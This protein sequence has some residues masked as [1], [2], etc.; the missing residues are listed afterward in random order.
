MPRKAFPRKD[1]AHRVVA[2]EVLAKHAAATDRPIGLPVPID[3]II[4]QTYGLEIVWDRLAESPDTMILGALIPQSRRIVLNEVH[5]DMFDRWVGPER[6]TLAHELAHW[7]YDADN[8]DQLALD[9]KVSKT[10]Q[11]CYHPESPRLSD[12][13]R[14]REVNAN[15]LASHL[16]LPA[17]LV[18]AVP[19]D[20]ILDDFRGTAARW[21]VSQQALRIRLE[22]LGLIDD[23]DASRLDGM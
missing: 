9:L 11:F 16:L 4:E 7:I 20:T 8:P 12:H 23:M 14:I 19:V 6:F 2:T 21:G 5:S 10:E 17:H 15:K 18:R 1:D 3:L 22:S 13:L